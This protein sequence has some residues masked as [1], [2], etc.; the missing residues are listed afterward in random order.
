MNLTL[1]TVCVD[2]INT[3]VKDYLVTSDKVELLTPSDSKNRPITYFMLLKN[4]LCRAELELFS[5]L[6]EY[7]GIRVYCLCFSN[8]KTGMEM[9]RVTH[10][11]ET[12]EWIVSERNIELFANDD[13][14]FEHIH[15][16]LKEK[17][18]TYADTIEQ[19]SQRI[20][21]EVEV[22]NFAGN[23]V[24]AVYNKPGVVVKVY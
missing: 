24:G 15:N 23:V 11:V 1:K 5:A 21:D 13:D 7:E 17:Q 9:L 8:P 12:D 10:K 22:K 4:H 16:L 6:P 2:L 20:R 18:A 14:A 19:L 3:I